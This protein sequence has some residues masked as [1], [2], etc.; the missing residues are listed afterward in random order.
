MAQPLSGQPPR[1]LAAVPRRVQVV[2]FDIEVR[3]SS[4]SN[5]ANSIPPCIT[6]EEQRVR[7]PP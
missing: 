6:G 7:S 1:G 5:D 2:E 4:A 3:I